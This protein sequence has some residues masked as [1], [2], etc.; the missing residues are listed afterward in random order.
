M[1]TSFHCRHDQSVKLDL[2]KL[3]LLGPKN[4]LLTRNMSQI[5]TEFHEFKFVQL[6]QQFFSSI[7]KIYLAYAMV[8]LDNLAKENAPMAITISLTATSK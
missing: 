3:A 6:N 4:E 1:L 5:K 2:Q 8:V 7:K